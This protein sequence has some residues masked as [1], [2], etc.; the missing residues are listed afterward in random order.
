MGTEQ[1]LRVGLLNG[2]LGACTGDPPRSSKVQGAQVGR[3]ADRQR[4]MNATWIMAV[5]S[6]PQSPKVGEWA[7]QREPTGLH[8][9]SA[10]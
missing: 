2:G 3:N 1:H 8:F 7:C 10:F 4:P 9:V 6:G 5:Q